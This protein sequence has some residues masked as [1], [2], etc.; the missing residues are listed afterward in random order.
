MFVVP[1]AKLAR[2][3]APEGMI[4]EGGKDGAVPHTFQGFLGWRDNQFARLMV[5]DRRGLPTSLS[6]FG[7]LTPLAGL[8]VT[9]FFSQ[10]Y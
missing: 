1:D 9:A 3:L 4:D 10:R 5:G 8:W 6:T 7:R 2:L